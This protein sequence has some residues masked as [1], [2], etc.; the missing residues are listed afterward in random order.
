M[1]RDYEWL[2]HI[3]DIKNILDTNSSME[4]NLDT[5]AVAKIAE[6]AKIDQPL[7]LEEAYKDLKDEFNRQDDR[8]E[9]VNK[10]IGD[11]KGWENLS[12][13]DLI[14]NDV[15]D[16]DAY[17]FY[18]K[19][20]CCKDKFQWE[21]LQKRF[22]ETVEERCKK[23]KTGVLLLLRNDMPCSKRLPTHI[24]A[25]ILYAFPGRETEIVNL[26][27]LHEFSSELDFKK[28]ENIKQLTIK[29]YNL[30]KILTTYLDPDRNLF[31]ALAKQPNNPKILGFLTLSLLKFN[32]KA[33][34]Q[35]IYEALK[36]AV[37]EQNLSNVRAIL[38]EYKDGQNS[39]EG[40]YDNNINLSRI[41]VFPG[42]GPS[43]RETPFSTTVFGE[44]FFSS[45]I[46]K[47]PFN[48]NRLENKNP[49]FNIFSP[50]IDIM[51]LFYQ[52]K[53]EFINFNLRSYFYQYPFSIKKNSVL[54]REIIAINIHLFSQNSY[55]S[56]TGRELFLYY[57]DVFYNRFVVLLSNLIAPKEIIL[58]L[59]ENNLNILTKAGQEQ[60]KYLKNFPEFVKNCCHGRT[61]THERFDSFRRLGG[62]V[63][64]ISPE[65]ALMLEKN[66]FTQD[67]LPGRE[68]IGFFSEAL[69]KIFSIIITEIKLPTVINQVIFQYIESSIFEKI[70]G[71]IGKFKN[72]IYHFSYTKNKEEDL[73]FS[74][75]VVQQSA[76][77]EDC[78]AWSL[79]NACKFLSMMSICPAWD[80][81]GELEPA[82]IKQQ[83]GQFAEFKKWAKIFLSKTAEDFTA[84]DLE[85]I[86]N[87]AGSEEKSATEKWFPGL[88]KNLREMRD[89]A[90]MPAYT[91]INSLLPDEDYKLEKSYTFGGCLPLQ[92]MRAAINFFQLYKRQQEGEK[93]LHCVLIGT[94]AHWHVEFLAFNYSKE[95]L[96]F[97]R[98]D[99][100][101]TADEVAQNA[102]MYILDILKNP[103]RYAENV[104]EEV[105]PAIGTEISRLKEITHKR[106]LDTLQ[107]QTAYEHCRLV[108]DFFS[109]FGGLKF[110]SQYSS[111]FN[112][113][114][115]L[116]FM[117]AQ[118]GCS[119]FSEL[120]KNLSTL[121]NLNGTPARLGGFEWML[122]RQSPKHRLLASES[123]RMES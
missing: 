18:D 6:A 60:L 28:T 22:I 119:K 61:S 33:I 4:K 38:E 69:K 25:Q 17:N 117:N 2:Y 73:I 26:S 43:S 24:Y 82:Q 58:R 63:N 81:N 12:W 11:E 15:V 55:L 40:F 16:F 99:S 35:V 87:H 110:A 68:E 27:R 95:T 31:I 29:S 114:T 56:K 107:D 91:I 41:K 42:R 70:S 7:S 109:N 80:Y 112:L 30:Y 66:I 72:Y 47:T 86:L 37:V 3:P 36:G 8:F 116:A 121:H 115:Q 46:E 59:Y 76:N 20:E 105:I 49:T 65:D 104:A 122:A 103:G 54:S 14:K 123:L 45:C 71:G 97:I 48:L 90:E 9:L 94:M 32:S 85:N 21:F 50:L 67:C 79:F 57:S 102:R 113:A 51:L 64:Y 13:F 106:G 120:H 10:F 1:R 101:E 23:S 100:A 62:L 88:H 77:S 92:K 96:Y 74:Y 111:V 75:P 89:T 108:L 53:N 52:Y 39:D 19:D 83:S 78:G 118:E 98:M 44:S 5:L 84:L 34:P 93:I